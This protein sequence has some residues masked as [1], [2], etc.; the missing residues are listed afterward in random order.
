MTTEPGMTT[1]PRPVINNL[2]RPF[3]EG[4]ERGKLVLPHCV[5]TGAAFWPPGPISPFA[6]NSTVE[7]REVPKEGRVRAVAVYHRSFLKAFEALVP[8]GIAQVEIVDGVRLN[9]HVSDAGSAS[10]WKPGDV[11]A[12]E[13]RPLIEDGVPV[14]SVSDRKR[15]S[16]G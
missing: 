8:Y 7:W 6:E 2:N 4:A 9:A 5:R 14:L 12:L 3:W 16:D 1:A 13:F 10:A 11:V 15:V